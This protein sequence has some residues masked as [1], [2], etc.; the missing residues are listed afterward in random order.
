MILTGKIIKIPEFFMIFARKIN[1]IAE[2]YMIFAR[3]MPEFYVIIAGKNI[4]P[5]FFWGG[6][7][8]PAPV[9]YTP[10]SASGPNPSLCPWVDNGH[11]STFQSVPPPLVRGHTSHVS[12]LSTP[13]EL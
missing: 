10:M 4:F 6:G 1:R 9:S 7:V 8:P 2:F 12:F 3:K 5:I 13:A 11:S